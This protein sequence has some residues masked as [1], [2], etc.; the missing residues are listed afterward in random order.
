MKSISAA[1]F[2]LALS[3]AS[4]ATAQQGG[5]LQCGGTE[6]FWGLTITATAM[7]LTNLDQQRVDLVLVKPQN[8]M[9]RQQDLVRVYQTRRVKGGGAVTF[10][11]TR[12]EQS[13]S[14]GMSD[15][16]Y[17]YNA[18]YIGPEGV[19]EGCCSWAK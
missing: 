11:V 13:C 12:N 7:W 6:P 9:A 4:A 10:V 3:S 8:A 14:D 5:S 15:K 18:V 17:A 2:A 19:M 16:R 1:V